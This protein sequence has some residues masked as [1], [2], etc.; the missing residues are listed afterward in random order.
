M[1]P[2]AGFGPILG[3]IFGPEKPTELPLLTSNALMFMKSSVTALLCTAVYCVL[4][5]PLYADCKSIWA[6]TGTV[7]TTT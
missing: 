1:A 4:G 6:G 3:S 7:R 5:Q 2:R